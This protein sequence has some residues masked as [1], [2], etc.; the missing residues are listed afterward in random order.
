MN[1][2]GGGTVVVSG[3]S[4]AAAAVRDLSSQH[5]QPM[6]KVGKL[7][8]SRTP[9]QHEMHRSNKGP[10]TVVDSDFLPAT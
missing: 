7:S 2:G 6:P 5:V 1:S 4:A 3:A 10:N 8:G 9:S